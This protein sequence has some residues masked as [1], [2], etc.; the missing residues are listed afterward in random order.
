MALLRQCLQELRL[1]QGEVPPLPLDSAVA[2]NRTRDPYT[3]FASP[4]L[5]HRV[6]P[7]TNRADK[8]CSVPF[9]N[10]RSTASR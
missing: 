7:F 9:L 4:T 3:P 6:D 10:P 2:R 8:P 1:H 5:M